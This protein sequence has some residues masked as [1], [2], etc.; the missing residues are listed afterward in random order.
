MSSEKSIKDK[1]I[2][3]TIRYNEIEYSH[4]MGSVGL[5]PKVYHT[6]FVK[7]SKNSI[8]QYTLMESFDKNAFETLKS[9]IALSEKLIL[10]KSMI[11]LLKKQ[12]FEYGLFCIDTKPQNFVCNVSDIVQ[13]VRI[14][15]FGRWCFFGNVLQESAISYNLKEYKKITD[16]STI[17]YLSQLIQLFLVIKYS[18]IELD[19]LLPFY[20]DKIFIERN[21]YKDQLEELFGLSNKPNSDIGFMLYHYIKSFD[22][23]LDIIDINTIFKY[24]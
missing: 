10:V 3:E 2:R 5:G 18:R 11:N 17:V 23:N 24:I 12:I 20:N 6:F 21:K 7:E 13:E 22:Q 1:D 16:I 19:V 8:K 14:I 15:D 9:N 4:Y